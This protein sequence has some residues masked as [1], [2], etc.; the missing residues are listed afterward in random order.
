PYDPKRDAEC[1]E[2]VADFPGEKV[3]SGG[4]SAEIVSR[5]L[6]L[7]LTMDLS[8]VSPE[9][10]PASKM[11][12]IDLVTEGI[13]T[14]TRTAQYLE[15]YDGTRHDNPAGQLADMMLR[16]D[17]IR[18]LV[19]T[20]INEAHQDPKLPQDLELR[21]NIVKRIVQVLEDRFLK[22]VDVRYV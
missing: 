7:K 8:Q 2:I 4:T 19:G 20:R 18:I 1:A 11:K 5:E 14:L 9:L 15:N 6:G 17:V 13:F 16:N 21:R 10:P 3:V 22:K 12:G